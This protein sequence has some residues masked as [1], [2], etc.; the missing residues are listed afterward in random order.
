MA[1]PGTTWKFVCLAVFH[2]KMPKELILITEA[3]MCFLFSSYGL[4]V[5][6]E[7]RLAGL[8]AVDYDPCKRFG[9]RPSTTP[10]EMRQ[11]FMVVAVDYRGLMVQYRRGRRRKIGFHT[12]RDVVCRIVHMANAIVCLEVQSQSLSCTMSFTIHMTSSK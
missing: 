6:R 5:Y 4:N 12:K 9:W 8:P 1:E 3:I 2:D 10:P 7:F 11:Y